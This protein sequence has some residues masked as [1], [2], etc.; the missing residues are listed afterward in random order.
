MCG[1]VH[2]LR[3]QGKALIFITLRDPALPTR[4]NFG[5][6]S[7]K[8]SNRERERPDRSEYI[9]RAIWKIFG[10]IR[11]SRCTTGVVI[12]IICYRWQFAAGINNTSGTGGTVPPVSL[13]P[14]VQPSLANISANFLKNS[15]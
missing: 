10:D 12:S 13:R 5:P 4:R 6:I 9:I 8:I 1:W 3:T 2:R 7:Q 15:K 14:V 11:S